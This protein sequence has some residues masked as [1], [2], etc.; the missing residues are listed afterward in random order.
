MPTGGQQSTAN[1]T[2]WLLPQHPVPACPISLCCC[3]R[4][5]PPSDPIE[6][7]EV[8]L[9]GC[10]DVDTVMANMPQAIRIAAKTSCGP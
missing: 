9:A 3:C 5:V 1:N 2:P 8:A 6:R 4:W 7:L 10:K